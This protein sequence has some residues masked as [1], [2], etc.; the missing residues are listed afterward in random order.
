MWVELGCGWLWGLSPPAGPDSC[1]GWGREETPGYVGLV[2]YGRYFHRTVFTFTSPK[3]GG[4]GVCTESDTSRFI[5]GTVLEPT[6]YAH[7]F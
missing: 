1:L 3:E 2:L 6:G 5:M 7:L 4:E